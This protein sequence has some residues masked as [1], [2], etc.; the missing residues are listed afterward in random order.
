MLG[1]GA[2][3]SLG[4][5]LTFQERPG[6]SYVRKKPHPAQ[7]NSLSQ[8][9][10]RWLYQDYC[11]LWSDLSQADKQVWRDLARGTRLSGF[12]LYIKTKLNTLP[13]LA[14][15]WHLDHQ[16]G[17]VTPDSSLGGHP[18]TVVGC[19]TS[20]GHIHNS[21]YLDGLNDK[22]TISPGGTLEIEDAIT[23][24]CFVNLSSLTAGDHLVCK[25]CGAPNLCWTLQ[26]ESPPNLLHWGIR[27]GSAWHACLA[28]VPVAGHWTHIAGIFDGTQV[29]AYTNG[30]PGAP[31]PWVG[32]IELHPTCPVYIGCNRGD[33]DWAHGYID[34]VFIWN[35]ALPPELIKV[36]SER[37]WP[38]Q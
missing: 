19:I 1:L 3:G 10:H 33:R 8:M 5:T 32:Q 14:G 4:D 31:T 38:V 11:Y 29:I 24:E 37:R 34:H 30:T 26:L 2:R 28:V 9:Y 13:E 25:Q 21:F 18:G 36:H 23:V 20:P 16:T 15:I 22:V 17:G 6:T 7:P 27:G 35:I 12:Q